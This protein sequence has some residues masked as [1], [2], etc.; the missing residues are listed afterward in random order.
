MIDHMNLPVSDLL[1][2]K[3]FYDTVLDPLGYRFIAEDGPARG[4]GT[5]TWQFGIELV[6]SP[7]LKLHVAF[8]AQSSSHVRAFHNA[9]IGLGA[10]SI[11]EPG[12]R[13]VYGF[14]YYA[15]FV[16]DPDGHNIEAVFRG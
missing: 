14:G 8:I 2:S 1:K 9:A 4:Y 5:T 3:R 7:I 11:G 16:E 15:A 6:Q 12:L 10:H 13:P